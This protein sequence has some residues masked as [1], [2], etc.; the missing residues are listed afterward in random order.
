MNIIFVLIND[1]EDEELLED[2][3][4]MTETPDPICQEEDYCELISVSKCDEDFSLDMGDIKNIG[5]GHLL[6]VKFKLKKVCP[7]KKYSVLISVYEIDPKTE[8]KYKRGRKFFTVKTPQILPP[9][10]DIK[11]DCVHFILPDDAAEEDFNY[12]GCDDRQFK[13]CISS[14][15]AD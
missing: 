5:T 4:N 13:V 15:L 9:C 2:T 8:K 3:L 7:G 6:N 10:S 12:D 14:H 1:L 11:V